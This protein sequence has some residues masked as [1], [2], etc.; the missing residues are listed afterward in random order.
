[1][2]TDSTSDDFVDNVRRLDAARRAKERAIARPPRPQRATNK[3]GLDSWLGE[4][5]SGC[6]KEVENAAKGQREMTVTVHRYVSAS[7]YI[8]ASI[9]NAHQTNCSTPQRN[10]GG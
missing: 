6:V 4:L 3:A 2:T 1:M 10:A 9:A 5:L 7:T 8:S